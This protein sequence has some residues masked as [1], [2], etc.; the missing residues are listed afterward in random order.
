MLRQVS[1]V[2]FSM[3]RMSSSASQQSWTWPRMRSSRVV[4]DRAQP[5]RALHVPPAGFDGEQLLVGGCEVVGGQRVIGGAQQPLAVEVGFP[6]G[7]GGVDAQQSRGG[8]A[9][10][11]T[12]PGLGLE[13][14]DDIHR[15]ADAPGRDTSVRRWLKATRRLVVDTAPVDSTGTVRLIGA[16]VRGTPVP[17]RRGLPGTQRAVRHDPRPE[18][19]SATTAPR[20]SSARVARHGPRAQ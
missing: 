15:G 11:A 9:Q 13:A 14:A 10:A 18:P 16:I 5:E 2:V 7:G 19:R 8:A 20:S 12:Q 6:L 17:A 1:W 3:T 4:V